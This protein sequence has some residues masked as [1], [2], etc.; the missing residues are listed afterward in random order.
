VKGLILFGTLRN[1]LNKLLLASEN[2]V[3]S[4]KKYF[5]NFEELILMQ[6]VFIFS[7]NKNFHGNF[8]EAGRLREL[9]HKQYV[10]DA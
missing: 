3:I 1:F 9:D 7:K 2:S 8:P 4:K 6:E 5:K 10:L